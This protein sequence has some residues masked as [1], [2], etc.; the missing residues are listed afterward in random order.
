MTRRLLVV[1]DEPDIRAI[2]ARSLQALAG[3]EVETV[4]SGR[5]AL[6]RAAASRPDAILLDVMMPGLDGPGTVAELRAT[7]ATAQIPVVMLTAKVQPSELRRLEAM[8][9]AGVIAKPF[10]PM[11]LHERVAELLGWT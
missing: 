10:D 11:T 9:V 8:P 1:D 5:D 3:W 4:S 7:E 6:E 2:V